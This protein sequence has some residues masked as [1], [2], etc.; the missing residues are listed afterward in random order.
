MK[1][2]HIIWLCLLLLG[3]TVVAQAQDMTQAEQ[4][5]LAFV[6]EAFDTTTSQ[7][8]F[9]V[10]GTNNIVQDITAVTAAGTTT[11]LQKIN[12]AITGELQLQP[13]LAASMQLHQ[14]LDITV[15]GQ[16]QTLDQTIEMILLPDAFYMRFPS[17][18]PLMA[19]I[20]FPKDWVNLMENPDAFPGANLINAD[21]YL[22]MVQ[23]QLKY[24]IDETTT[25]AVQEL[26]AETIDGVE[27]RVI[28]IQ[29]DFE[30]LMQSEEM[31]AAMGIL[32]LEQMGLDAEQ[33]MESMDADNL[34]II[35]W[36]NPEDHL[37]YQQSSIMD[38]TMEMGDLF[39]GITSGT[40]NQHLEQTTSYSRYN[41]A[42]TI[43]APETPNQ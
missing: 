31:R 41:E 3:I 17:T 26:P 33:F 27:M 36:V 14:K 37:I 29:L 19:G 30:L 28:E 11:S 4:E 39:P 15:N 38:M 18:L 16:V 25:T 35:V 6:T 5:L 21:Q 23:S 2:Y 34:I 32:N 8:S 9:A 7:E 40:L 12:Q 13:T 24:Q 43:E 1:R 22:N 42:F 10:T 20:S